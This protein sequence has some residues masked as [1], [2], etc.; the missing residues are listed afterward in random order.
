[1]VVNSVV[2]FVVEEYKMFVNPPKTFLYVLWA[3]VLLKLF[4]K[5]HVGGCNT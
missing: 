1:M 4:F 3:P 2:L 5:R